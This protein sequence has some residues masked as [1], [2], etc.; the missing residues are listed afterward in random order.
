MNKFKLCILISLLLTTG[1]A[2]AQ[3]QELPTGS[4]NDTLAADTPIDFIPMELAPP[5]TPPA[6]SAP[7]T[8]ALPAEAPT[9]HPAASPESIKAVHTTVVTPP[10]SEE[11]ANTTV[12]A[13]KPHPRKKITSVS[14]WTA[15]LS[16]LQWNEQ[17]TVI[18]AGKTSYFPANYNGL[19][20][21]LSK[22]T[23]Y[24]RWGWNFGVLFGVGRASGGGDDAATTISYSQSKQAFSIMGITPR[25]FWRLTNR[26]NIG[27]SAFVY[28]RNITWPDDATTNVESGRRLNTTIIADL[29]IK[30]LN[31]WDFY[32]GIAPLEAGATLWKIGINYRFK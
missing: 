9:Q 22:E 13:S 23:T 1:L 12:T 6:T 11:T 19:A 17:L 4:E 27:G 3:V 31:Q 26:V 16:S 20:L 14:Q 29:N 30:L 32:Q 15:G 7:G 21:G 10:T 8:T 25:L 28:S 18:K 5:S 2:Q 24:L